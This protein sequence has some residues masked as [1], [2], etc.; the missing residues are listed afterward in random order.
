MNSTRNVLNKNVSESISNCLMLTVR[1]YSM[2][3]VKLILIETVECV[4]S[5]ILPSFKILGYE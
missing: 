2:K 3:Y 1:F 4:K 5:H